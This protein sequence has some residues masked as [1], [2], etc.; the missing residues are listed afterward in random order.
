MTPFSKNKV[1]IFVTD[2][3]GISFRVF[4]YQIHESIQFITDNI[5][6]IKITVT[7]VK[8]PLCFI[9]A[10]LSVIVTSQ[11]FLSRKKI[12]S[13]QID[14]LVKNCSIKYICL[15]TQ[16]L[17]QKNEFYPCSLLFKANF[18]AAHALLTQIF[19]NFFYSWYHLKQVKKSYLYGYFGVSF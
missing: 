5:W 4:L 3:K 14:E 8:N 16:L 9:N 1:F 6:K 17:Y 15:I 18:Y 19:S 10:L 7:F 13:F 2:W 11:I 12:Q